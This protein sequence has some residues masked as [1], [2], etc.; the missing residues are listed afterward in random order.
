MPRLQHMSIIPEDR[1]H[2]ATPTDGRTFEGAHCGDSNREVYVMEPTTGASEMLSSRASNAWKL[3]V[4]ACIEN[5]HKH[6]QC[7]DGSHS[8]SP[9]AAAPASCA[10]TSQGGSHGLSDQ[11]SEHLWTAGRSMVNGSSSGTAQRR[12]SSG[13]PGAGDTGRPGALPRR[14]EQQCMPHCS[15]APQKNGEARQASPTHVR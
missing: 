14:P 8:A 12:A 6:A 10:C 3:K 13:T 11:V 4:A 9:F 1:V 2:V 7:F 15:A 5:K